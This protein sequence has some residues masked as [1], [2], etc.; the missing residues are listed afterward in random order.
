MEDV[1]NASPHSFRL[2][3]P[4]IICLILSSS[5]LGTC[6]LKS[7]SSPTEGWS[8]TALAI[9]IATELLR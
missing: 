1:I 7:E 3:E 5:N 4:S 8:F 6:M 2:V 9:V